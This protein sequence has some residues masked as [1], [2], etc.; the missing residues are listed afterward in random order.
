MGQKKPKTPRKSPAKPTKRK[1]RAKPKSPIGPLG[2]PSRRTKAELDKVIDGLMRENTTLS[3]ECSA[4]RRELAAMTDDRNTTLGEKMQ[5]LNSLAI[6]NDDLNRAANQSHMDTKAFSELQ[7]EHAD[8]TYRKRLTTALKLVEKLEK[9]RE[10]RN[11]AIK[12]AAEANNKHLTHIIEQ[13]DQLA[14]LNRELQEACHEAAA[15]E[16][17]KQALKENLVFST[18][19]VK[20]RYDNWMAAMGLIA[21]LSRDFDTDGD[22]S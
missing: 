4:L 15:L 21:V 22:D 6:A 1:S 9:S 11:V 13:R 16:I 7:D 3:R 17:Q 8:T 19:A 12:E 18:T 2:R 20:A 14:I 10:R 5:A